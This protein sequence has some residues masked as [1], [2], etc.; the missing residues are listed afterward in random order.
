MRFIAY[1]IIILLFIGIG[2]GVMAPLGL[3]WLVPGLPLLVVV[4]VAME[5]DSWDYVFFA[6]VGGV[7][8]DTMYALPIGSFTAAYLL[9]GFL[10]YTVF[11]SLLWI[12][13]NWKYYLAFV[14]GADILL[15]VWLWAYTSILS[16]LQW[17]VLPISGAELLRHSWQI[18]IIH[19]IFAFPVYG[20]INAAVGR[21]KNLRRQPLQ[22]L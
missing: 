2:F 8:M 3:G 22:L 15:L 9:G 16:R 17:I 7:W 12:E 18:I 20:V 6:L 11:H 19:L 10:S 21:W 13:A 4:C 5:Y 14:L 1:I